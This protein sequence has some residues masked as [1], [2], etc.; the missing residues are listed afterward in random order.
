MKNSFFVKESI[1]EIISLVSIKNSNFLYS[2]KIDLPA[3]LK[4]KG[5]KKVFQSIFLFLLEK[6]K[7][8]YDERLLNMI[9]LITAKI[10]NDHELSLSVTYSGSGFSFLERELINRAALVL[11]DNY[12]N[13]QVCKVSKII[14]NQFSGNL[15]IISEKN[16]GA[17]LKCTFPL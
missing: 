16:K 2:S 4:I 12:K 11:N 3:E 1:Q 5:Q 8:A 17:T 10:E 9:I 15:K 13:F 6:A 7:V 14:K